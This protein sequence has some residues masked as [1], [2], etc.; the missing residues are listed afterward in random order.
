MAEN[1]TLAKVCWEASDCDPL[2]AIWLAVRMIRLGYYTPTRRGL[3]R[4]LDRAAA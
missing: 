2:L 4:N 3:E 1:R